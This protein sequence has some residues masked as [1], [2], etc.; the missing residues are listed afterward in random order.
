MPIAAIAVPRRDL[1]NSSK[2][3]EFAAGCAAASPMPTPSR[4]IARIVNPVAKAERPAKNDHAAMQNASNRV[5]IHPSTSRPR[6][7]ENSA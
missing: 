4:E 7:S 1:G 6:G 5:R 2:M 3:I